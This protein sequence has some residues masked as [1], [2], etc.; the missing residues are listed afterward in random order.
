LV[1]IGQSSV[2][3]GTYTVNQP[4][5]GANNAMKKWLRKAGRSA[6]YDQIGL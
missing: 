4:G 3:T 2:D 5:K 6:S 1:D